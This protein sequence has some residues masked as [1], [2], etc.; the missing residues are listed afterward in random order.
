MFIILPNK[1][2]REI[3]LDL[4]NRLKAD[5]IENMIQKATYKSATILIPKL[6]IEQSSYIQNAMEKMGVQALFDPRQSDLSLLTAPKAFKKAK[7]PKNTNPLKRA[8]NELDGTRLSMNSMNSHA[9]VDKIIHK[10][11]LTVD[12]IGTEG[13]AAT[14]TV[15]NKMGGSIM[16]LAQTPF[17]F[18]I[19]HT[20][21]KLPL[22]YGAVFEPSFNK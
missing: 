1:S 14:G 17:L 19:R 3:T 18:L 12:E 20:A 7:S 10:V 16:F 6:H 9:Y 21:T 8:L 15:I 11:V 13:G 22:F 4:L 5:D 2:N